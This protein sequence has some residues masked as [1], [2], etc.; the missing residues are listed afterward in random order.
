MAHIEEPCTLD[1]KTGSPLEQPLDF[2]WP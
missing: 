1:R 2:Y